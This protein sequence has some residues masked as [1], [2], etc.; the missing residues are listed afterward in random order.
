MVDAVS[1]FSHDL[2]TLAATIDDMTIRTLAAQFQSIIGDAN[3]FYNPG[4][5]VP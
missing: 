4:M 1:S 3:T 2:P 5:Y